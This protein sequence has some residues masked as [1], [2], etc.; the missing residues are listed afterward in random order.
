[1]APG[2][3]APGTLAPGTLA[4]GTVAPFFLW[5]HLYDPHA[6]YN[7]PREFIRATNHES[8]VPSI[9]QRYEGE[10]RYADAHIARVF[11][12]LNAHAM[13]EHTLIV[14]V[15]DHGEG[16]GEHGERTH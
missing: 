13:R 12:W 4:P 11:E 7:P 8:R 14:V 16:L 15:G 1:V 3:L 6:P 9:E 10:I 2:T 5:I